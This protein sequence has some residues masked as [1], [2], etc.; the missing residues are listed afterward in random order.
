M[1][2][3]IYDKFIESDNIKAFPTQ[4]E[5]KPLS[6]AGKA[7]RKFAPLLV[8]SILIFSGVIPARGQ[9]NKK[10]K[11]LNEMNVTEYVSHMQTVA[12][13]YGIVDL[14]EKEYL[15][16]EYID[17]LLSSPVYPILTDKNYNHLMENNKNFWEIVKN[18][19]SVMKKVQNSPKLTNTQK[20]EYKITTRKML[21]QIT[22]IK[23]TQD[24]IDVTDY[25]NMKSFLFFE[26]LIEHKDNYNFIFLKRPGKIDEQ[27]E[28]F[29]RHY[30]DYQK[31]DSLC[32]ENPL[33]LDFAEDLYYSKH[34]TI[35]QPEDS[36]QAN[37]ISYK[38]L[39]DWLA[40]HHIKEDNLWKYAE[41]GSEKY[42]NMLTFYYWRKDDL[43]L[44]IKIDPNGTTGEDLYSPIGT[45]IAH[46]L[47]H[48]M[49]KPPS[50]KEKPGDNKKESVSAYGSNRTNFASELG[51][52]LLNLTLDDLIY[53]KI[54]NIPEDKI[55]NHGHLA[56]NN[57]NINIGQLAVW[58]NKKMKKYPNMGVDQI[59]TQPDVFKDLQNLSKPWKE[60]NIGNDIH[61]ERW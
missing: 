15:P 11:K 34:R 44:N 54:H 59:L 26:R 53:K 49:Q 51:P 52:T 30:K 23:G 60:R 43:L 38:I 8:S 39:H 31:L 32:K 55:V 50:S 2:S 48:L 5:Q 14:K 33:V 57:R 36:V 21:S 13:K 45:T 9:E 40:Q 10:D 42:V 1:S 58:F 29:G 7:L 47:V 18:G 19:I 12:D 20:Q 4:K 35:I 46:E 25:N 56:N 28:V 22:R 16:Q 3:S 41:Y 37:K 61:A 24:S 17:G 6:I 27:S